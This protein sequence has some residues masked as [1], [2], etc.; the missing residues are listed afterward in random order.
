[1]SAEATV[2][3]D[4]IFGKKTIDF[5]ATLHTTTKNLYFGN[6]CYYMGCNNSDMKCPGRCFAGFDGAG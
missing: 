5:D 1:M 4:D 3:L 6:V 2:S